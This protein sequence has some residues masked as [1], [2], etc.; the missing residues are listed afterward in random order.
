M[1]GETE[2]SDFAGLVAMATVAALDGCPWVEKGHL[3]E[4]SSTVAA[5]AAERA[6]EVDSLLLPNET[7]FEKQELSSPPTVRGTQ[8]AQ[9]GQVGGSSPDDLGVD[10]RDP[11]TGPDPLRGNGHVVESLGHAISSGEHG[12]STV[13]G[14]IKRVISEGSWREFVTK[15]GEL[16]EHESFASFVTTPPLRGL[17]SDMALLRRIVGDDPEAVDLLDQA[18]Q[19]PVGANQHTAGLDN[20]QAHAP[21]G[22]S[23]S[24]ALRRL[25]KDRPDLHAQVLNHEL[26]AHAAAVQAGFRPKTF[27]L[28]A[29]NPEKIAATLRRQLPQDVLQRVINHLEGRL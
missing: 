18:L 14:L 22:T 21:T 11:V 25:R 20:I 23:E 8:E 19:Q 26:S 7:L 6:S 3:W 1:S 27:T 16:V 10:G 2:Q 29:D 28:R 4:L 5:L 15:R 24:A 12:L 17:G 13:P 9:R